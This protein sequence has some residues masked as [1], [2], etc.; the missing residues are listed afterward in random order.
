MSQASS[1]RGQP[2]I[3]YDFQEDLKNILTAMPLLLTGY[4]HSSIDISDLL[5]LFFQQKDRNL[6]IQKWNILISDHL[7]SKGFTDFQALCEDAQNGLDLKGYLSKLANKPQKPD[8]MLNRWG[9]NHFHSDN[10]LRGRVGRSSDLLFFVQRD[11]NLYFIDICSHEFYNSELLEVIEE[12]W[13]FLFDSC[14]D[15]NSTVTE[16]LPQEQAENVL[17]KKG[18]LLHKL[19]TGR[20]IY[21][22]GGGTLC[23]GQN[24]LHRRDAV[25]FLV[26]LNEPQELIHQTMLDYGL[27][28]LR[29]TSKFHLK[30]IL[31]N[32]EFKIVPEIHMELNCKNPMG[33]NL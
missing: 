4:K 21:P 26:E 8:Y 20:V 28:S 25:A 14:V 23:N 7:Q 2:E 33:N 16:N 19:N 32:D 22:S 6:K 12:N 15:T 24:I 17:I 3:T 10:H 1:A 31:V 29:G 9:I 11:N 13:P 27:Y 18:N 30:S 5:V